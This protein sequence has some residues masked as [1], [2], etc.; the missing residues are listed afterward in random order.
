MRLEI[1]KKS[2]Y[3]KISG[4]QESCATDIVI[5]MSYA[6][7]RGNNDAICAIDVRGEFLAS[8]A[9]CERLCWLL[10][11]S[12]KVGDMVDLILR[13]S[14]LE[15]KHNKP[16]S[17]QLRWHESLGETEYRTLAKVDDDTAREI[18]RAGACGWL[19]GAPDWDKRAK[20]RELERARV[21]EEEAAAIRAKAGS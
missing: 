17:L 15:E 13:P 3:N 2:A 5:S 11:E 1:S 6:K 9:P 16:W 7:V 8:P 20:A 4:A 18:I 12:R 10:S 19:F 21:L 14:G